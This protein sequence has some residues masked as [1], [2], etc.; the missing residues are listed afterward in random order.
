MTNQPLSSF[1]CLSFMNDDNKNLG[2]YSRLKG[3]F[4]TL[5]FSGTVKRQVAPSLRKAFLLTMVLIGK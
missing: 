3:L 5:C 1:S 2:I 4:K